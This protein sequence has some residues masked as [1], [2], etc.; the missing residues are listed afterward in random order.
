[1]VKGVL[2][3][4]VVTVITKIIIILAGRLGYR[5]SGPFTVQ[6]P[7]EEEIIEC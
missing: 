3:Q 1:M 7:K 2:V 4:Q 5:R 6:Q